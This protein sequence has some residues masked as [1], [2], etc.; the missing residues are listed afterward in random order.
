MF[1]ELAS[2]IQKKKISNSNSD[3]PFTGADSNPFWLPRNFW[4]SEKKISDSN[5]D[6]PF[7]GA[8]SNPFWLPRNFFP[9]L[10]KANI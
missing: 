8:D 3:G 10:K 1:N 5:S 9:Q 2:E 4:N 6:G 7:N